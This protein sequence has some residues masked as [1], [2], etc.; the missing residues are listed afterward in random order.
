MS[1]MATPPL[2]PTVTTK[3]RMALHKWQDWI[4][5]QNLLYCCWMFGVMEHSG[6]RK[7]PGPHLPGESDPNPPNPN[8]SFAPFQ[9]LELVEFPKASRCLW[10]LFFGKNMWSNFHAQV[11]LFN[12][13]ENCL[14]NVTKLNADL[15]NLH[16]RVSDTL[17]GSHHR[18]LA[19]PRYGSH[20]LLLKVGLSHQLWAALL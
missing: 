1:F 11:M 3:P 17:L 14:I 2:E 6:A 13:A 19:V 8:P 16:C 15:S 7:W 10:V 9:F 18:I 5:L 12:S 4:L 20:G